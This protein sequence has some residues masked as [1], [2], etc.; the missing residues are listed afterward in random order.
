[1]SA[2]DKEKRALRYL[3]M[4]GFFR[5]FIRAVSTDSW[6]AFRASEV[7]GLAEASSNISSPVFFPFFPD[8]ALPK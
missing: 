3:G 7:T 2:L 8:L 6:S 4:S 1:M 5:L